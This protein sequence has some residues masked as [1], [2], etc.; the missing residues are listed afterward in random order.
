[1]GKYF[2][3]FTLTLKEY[4]AYRLNFLIWRLRVFIGFLVPFFLWLTVTKQVKNFAGYEG[5]TII[6]Y[7][8]FTHLLSYFILGTRTVD[9]AGQ[10]QNGEILNFLL[11]PIS[12]FHYYFF[13]D[14]ADKILNFLLSFF[15]I[16]LF[17]K[18]F[19]LPFPSINCQFLPF[20]FLFL[21]SGL[22]L[23]FYLSLLISFSGF[24]SAEVWAP[25]FIFF[26]LI[27]ILSGSFFPLDLLPQKLFSLILFTPF[28]YL[29]FLPVK[30]ISS[31]QTLINKV[32]FDFLFFMGSF[33]LIVFFFLARFFWQKGLKSFSFWGR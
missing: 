8:F 28:P 20:F 3:V 29:F 10:I 6:A 12:F 7:F 32:N 2:S 27:S 23:N 17:F 18:I 22:F 25:R 16:F 1:M 4:F 26:I 14:L 11:K 31:P 19:S 15:E 33:W 30:M 13:R 5:K 24:W 21:T 9:I